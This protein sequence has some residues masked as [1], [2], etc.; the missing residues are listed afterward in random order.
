MSLT[1]VADLLRDAV[2]G[3]QIGNTAECVTARELAKPVIFILIGQPDLLENTRLYLT[4][5]ESLDV[6]HIP[7][8]ITQLMEN[9]RLRGDSFRAHMA[10]DPRNSRV[11]SSCAMESLGEV[12]GASLMQNR[13]HG[14][15][16]DKD[17]FRLMAYRLNSME[18]VKDKL[19]LRTLDQVFACACK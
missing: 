14:V 2:Q 17:N 1:T 3:K 8:D 10:A 7:V 12:R 4:L 13:S 16:V 5:G 15:L 18:Y 19:S 6:A 11:T 9:I